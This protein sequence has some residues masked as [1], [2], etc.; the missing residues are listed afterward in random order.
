M[1]RADIYLQPDAP[2]PVLPEA[3]VLALA[4]AHLPVDIPVFTVD[5]VDESGG[6]ARAYLLGG[7]VVVKVQ[8]PHRLR[9]RTSL[10]K[11]AALLTALA[12]P[13]AGRVPAVFGHDRVQTAHGPVEFLV[14]S[15]VK[16]RPVGTRSLT[17]PARRAVLAEVAAVLRLVHALDVPGLL[18]AGLL[19]VDEDADALRRRLALGFAD[20]VDDLDA[21]PR[22]AALPVP[23]AQVA[24]RAL[25]ALPVRLGQ[26]PVVLHSNPALTHV[27]TDDAGVF[28]GLIDFGDAYASHPALDLRSW[29]DPDD[30]IVLRDCYLDGRSAG[31]VWEAVWTVAMI[32]AD[33]AAV[34]G[35]PAHVAAAAADIRLRL[36]DL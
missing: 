21:R 33:L 10:A 19:P 13:L 6:E 7:G 25:G 4:R 11:E 14:M 30:R 1:G 17:G 5:R 22:S 20:L 23:A 34:A 32:H 9:P 18:P 28:T 15:R 29:P 16:G 12:G 36:D 2:D 35:R 24:G 27:F 31:P 8:R 3:L 26:D